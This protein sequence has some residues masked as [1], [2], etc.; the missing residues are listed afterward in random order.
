MRRAADDAA[1]A[2]VSKREGAGS[3]ERVDLIVRLS[4]V[5]ASR[6]QSKAFWNAL[7]EGIFW[8]FASTLPEGEGMLTRYV[9]I[10]DASF[11]PVEAKYTITKVEGLSNRREGC[12]EFKISLAGEASISADDEAAT[13]MC[14][15][16][17]E[18]KGRAIVCEGEPLPV[19]SETVFTKVA[20]YAP[21][22]TS[23]Y[24]SPS[25]ERIEAAWARIP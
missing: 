19:A 6:S 5:A 12:G 10:E 1:Y 18:G 16:S 21:W 24:S 7:A 11:T 25:E 3:T 20:R 13:G 4:D 8:P 14:G 2:F 22:F 15:M 9:T 17:I 23:G